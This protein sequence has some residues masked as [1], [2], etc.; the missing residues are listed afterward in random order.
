MKHFARLAVTMMFLA[1]FSHQAFSETPDI[2][3]Q[4]T[5]QEP[6]FTLQKV[7]GP[8]ENPWS[9][10]FLPEDGGIL[11]TERAGRL[12]FVD[13][14]SGEL[15]EVRGLPEM[16]IGSHAGLMDVILDPDFAENQIVY[17][18]LTRGTTDALSVNVFKARFDRENLAL[19]DGRIIFI[20]QPPAPGIEQL[21][22]RLAIDQ[23][24]YLYLTLGDRFS[25]DRAQDLTD[26][27][28]SIIR[29]TRE[30]G[31][32]E[33]NPF[34][35]RADARPEIWTFGHRNPQGL[36]VDGKTGRILATEHGPAG[37]DELNVIEKG[38]NYGWP[39]TS[40]GVHYDGS[41]V[42]FGASMAGTVQPMRQWTPSIAPSGLAIYSDNGPTGWPGSLW[43]GGL[44]GQSI[45]RLEFSKGAIVGEKRFLREEIG[46]IRDVRLAPNGAIYVVT[47][48]AHGALY[49]LDPIIEQVD[50]EAPFTLYDREVQ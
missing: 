28:G 43:I 50:I 30:G 1:A 7:A 41:S 15:S 3:E 4:A 32:P 34:R 22:G 18:S 10:A 25:G 37:G 19:V 9:I 2:F 23:A 21:G 42:P 36:V 44:S 45:I 20:S 8:F 11:V 29:I 48:D 17:L 39:L 6:D 49:R 13:H 12:Q 33:D 31:V 5:P 38:M 14:A 24:G 46:R 35:K 26:H 40:Y 47:D 16:L 27:A